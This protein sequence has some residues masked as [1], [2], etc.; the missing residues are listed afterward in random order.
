MFS[1]IAAVLFFVITVLNVLLLCGLPLGELTMGGQYKVLPKHLKIPAA[2]SLL[3]QVFAIFIVLQAGG[4][5]ELWFS[6][7]VTRI[8]C[9]I[10]AGYLVLNSCMCLF[11]KSKKEKYIMTPLA[12]GAAVCFFIT[13][14]TMGNDKQQRVTEYVLEHQ[15]ELE[16]N[17]KA[18]FENGEYLSY[19][20]EI[21]TANVWDGEH[22]MVEYMMDEPSG[23]TYYGFYYSPDDAPLAFQ[24]ANYPCEETE[25]GWTWH[26]E[27]DN[28]GFTS[29]IT[30]GWYYFEATF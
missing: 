26:A 23:S 24:N 10:Y 27:G 8:I 19:A 2:S 25:G 4:Y 13:A 30:D 22:P 12:F 21:E 3:V 14:F 16:Q 18:Y 9:Y 5:L 6:F 15:K 1:I 28:H 11:S 29:R 20:G 17:A 7:K